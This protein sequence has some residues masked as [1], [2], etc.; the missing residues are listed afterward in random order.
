MMS[1]L[2]DLPRCLYIP[3]D[4]SSLPLYKAIHVFPGLVV[5]EFCTTDI[6]LTLPPVR[7]TG[8]GDMEITAGDWSTS[9]TAKLI[10]EKWD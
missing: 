1:P 10:K 6:A 4:S 7:S 5:P 9:L 3:G 8:V 2:G